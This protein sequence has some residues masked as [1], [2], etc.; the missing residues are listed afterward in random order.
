MEQSLA[1]LEISRTC[2]VMTLSGRV[3]LSLWP[4]AGCATAG[5]SVWQRRYFHTGVILKCKMCGGCSNQERKL[6]L[7]AVASDGSDA[8]R[9]S[10]CEQNNDWLLQKGE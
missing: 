8:L 10:R 4:F 6:Q 3:P 5:P 1:D 2:T 7:A 9:P